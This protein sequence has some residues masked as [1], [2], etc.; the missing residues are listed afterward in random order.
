VFEKLDRGRLSLL[1]L[2]GF[3]VVPS[4]QA[5][6]VL[7]WENVLDP[8]GSSPMVLY[9]GLDDCGYPDYG[10]IGIVPSIGE[11]CIVAVNLDQPTSSAITTSFANGTSVGNAVWIYVDVKPFAGMGTVNAVVSGEWHATGFPGNAGCTATNPNPFSVPITIKSPLPWRIMP[12]IAPWTV[13]I[14]TRGILSGL[15]AAESLKGPWY[16]VGFGSNFTLSADQNL[17]FYKGTH[18]LGSAFGGLITDGSGSPQSGFS[19]GLQYGGLNTMTLTDGSFSFYGLPRGTNVVAV[20]KPITFVDSSTG[21]N[22]TETIGLNVEVPATNPTN[23][24]YQMM[25]LKVALALFPLPA[26]NCTPWCAIGVGTLNGAQTPV[27]YSGGALPPKNGAAN[28]GAVQ[29]TVTPPSGVAFPIVAG[30]SKHQNSGPNP[31]TGTWT[32]TTTVCGQSKQA[33]ITVP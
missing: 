4:V 14:D 16:N 7:W 22:R 23:I 8:S 15:R 17:Q 18:R 24:F 11:P 26:C 6:D 30:S 33:S 1:V 13:Q 27:F 31:A 25:Q 12:G 2:L 29:V 9:F 3:L 5:H 21:S 10:M 32:V 28:C 20:T 19:V